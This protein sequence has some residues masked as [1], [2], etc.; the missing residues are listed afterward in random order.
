MASPLFR[1]RHHGCSQAIHRHHREPS[2]Q[3]LRLLVYLAFTLVSAAESLASDNP[4]LRA[5]PDSLMTYIYNA[6]ESGLDNRYRYQW[7]I[8]RTALERTSPKY[9][10][11]RMTASE[12]M[13][14][15]RQT[16]ELLHAT[17]KISV[18]YL[19][20]TPEREKTLLP[21]HI[22]VDKNLVGYRIFLIRSDSRNRFN[23]IRT[24]DD[25]RGFRFG[26]G[27]GWADVDILKANNFKVVTGSNYEGLFEMLV[28]KR[29]DIFSR[30][31]E[32]I[33]DEYDLRKK[34]LPQLAIEQ[35]LILYYPLPMYFWFSKTDEGR[36]LAA[37][38]EEGMRSM[39]ADG[40]YDRI[41]DRYFK[42]TLGRLKLDKRRI[43][44]INNPLLGPETPMNDARLWFDPFSKH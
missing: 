22:P 25:L 39:L 30:G 26:L 15:H 11:Y 34:K 5:Q 28:Q 16:L 31:A 19:D 17:G 24:V 1:R 41:F 32:E 12:P 37:R 36:K 8:L 23:S 10:P 4:T 2:R 27:L 33:V 6:P 21:I 3:S 40:T 42:Q 35:T 18:M 44:R 13:S 14:E 38:T 43:L 7:E 9:G 20:T 29:F